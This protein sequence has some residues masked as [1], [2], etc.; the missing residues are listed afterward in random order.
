MLMQRGLLQ[1]EGQQAATH[2]GLQRKNW[3]V[4]DLGQPLSLGAQR[5]GLVKM[6]ND[7]GFISQNHITTFMNLLI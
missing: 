2:E 7:R 5:P 4:E 6:Q 1:K 3:G